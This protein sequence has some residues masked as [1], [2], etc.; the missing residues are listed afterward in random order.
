MPWLNFK[1][2]ETRPVWTA[3]FWP[4][5]MPSATA[6]QGETSATK[7]KTSLRSKRLMLDW[8][9]ECR[10][11]LGDLAFG[12]ESPVI[13]YVY[14]HPQNQNASKYEDSRASGVY[15][16]HGNPHTIHH[17]P[18]T[19]PLNCPN[20]ISQTDPSTPRLLPTTLKASALSVKQ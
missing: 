18:I 14:T 9:F 5:S 7:D 16:H 15:G 1:R 2:R 8:G 19:L 4:P 13:L 6:R 3:L 12:A 20:A 10:V 11:F 17:S